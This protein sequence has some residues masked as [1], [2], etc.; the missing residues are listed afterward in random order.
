MNRKCLKRFP[1]LY[2]SSFGGQGMLP[3]FAQDA[4]QTTS[5]RAMVNVGSQENV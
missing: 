5:H 2:S 3:L 4:F 1:F